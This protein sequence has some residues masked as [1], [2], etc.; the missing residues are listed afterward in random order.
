MSGRKLQTLP[1][2]LVEK[3]SVGLW[4]LAA[5]IYYQNVIVCF[6]V[7]IDQLNINLLIVHSVD[8]K[9]WVTFSSL[10]VK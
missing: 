8:L 7:Y 5:S 6:K 4:L 2:L 10:L 3:I 1:V 9:K